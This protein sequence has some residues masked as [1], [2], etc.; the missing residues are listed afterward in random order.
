MPGLLFETSTPPHLVDGRS[1]KPTISTMR[2]ASTAA[3]KRHNSPSLRLFFDTSSCMDL[4]GHGQEPDRRPR[5]Q[6]GRPLS[7]Y[8]PSVAAVAGHA[9]T[10]PLPQTQWSNVPMPYRP[11]DWTPSQ[12]I[13]TQEYD[14]RMRPY[15]LV[16]TVPRSDVPQPL[17]TRRRPRALRE[18]TLEQQTTDLSFLVPEISP[19]GDRFSSNSAPGE[20]QHTYRSV[21]QPNTPPFYHQ[22]FEQ[23]I[24]PV[25]HIPRSPTYP[26]AGRRRIHSAS[27]VTEAAFADE[28]E[29]RLFVDA[30]AGLGPESA[31]REP[32]NLRTRQRTFRHSSPEHMVSPVESTPTTMQA[33]R[34]LAQMPQGSESSSRRR[35][36]TSAG[37]LDLWL[38]PPSANGSSADLG[39]PEEEDELPPDDE[40]PDYAESQ[41]Q[42]QAAQRAEATRRARELQQRWHASGGQR[43]L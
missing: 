24:S 20:L 30:T 16:E 17:R 15:S 40:L 12:Q 1:D 38:Q 4:R 28:E 37:G 9:H 39:L 41:A 7:Q 36:Q 31:F 22:H 42:A 8:T 5:P 11:R 33:Y 43:G 14:W 25:V 34:H 10:S 21:S 18:P 27:G 35:L 29:F 3:T 6:D 13:P 26:P 32:T 2:P 19:Y 23:P